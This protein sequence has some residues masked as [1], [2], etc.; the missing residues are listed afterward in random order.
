MI[1]YHSS[2]TSD[3]STSSQQESSYVSDTSPTPSS[4][5][6]R[7]EA[8]N[9]TSS[10]FIKGEK[11]IYEQCSPEMSSHSSSSG[12]NEPFVPDDDR[13]IGGHL[14]TCPPERQYLSI[15]E[16]LLESA[17]QT[18]ESYNLVSR[19]RQSPGSSETTGNFREA[20]EEDHLKRFSGHHL[21]DSDLQE[22]TLS[23]LSSI[24]T[25][26]NMNSNESSDGESGW[27]V[28]RARYINIAPKVGQHGN[29]KGIIVKQWNIT[30][31][32][33]LYQ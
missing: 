33:L 28:K 6:G 31:T 14:I 11:G 24:A 5:P 21:N 32:E 13:A 22:T 26:S 2:S 7:A 20:A 12:Y 3:E 27:D 4:S 9:P 17:K 25:T 15:K 23:E 19:K 16:K 8:S 18:I 10:R 30:L 1:H 29:N